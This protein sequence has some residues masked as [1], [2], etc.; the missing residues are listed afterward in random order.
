MGE[1][2]KYVRFD[3]LLDAMCRTGKALKQLRVNNFSKE[4]VGVSILDS[5]HIGDDVELE[6]MIPGDNMPVMLAGEVAWVNEHSSS[7]QAC[8]GGIKLKETNNAD[9]SRMLGYIYQKWIMPAKGE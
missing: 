2:R 3:V 4:G 7:E 5:L 9:R 6:L 1:K 8:R